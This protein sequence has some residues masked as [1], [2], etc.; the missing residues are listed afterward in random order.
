MIALTSTQII[1]LTKYNYN[2][3]SVPP[4]DCVDVRGRGI[5]HGDYFYFTIPKVCSSS[6]MSMIDGESELGSEC[7][8]D[9][10]I[11]KKPV[12][13]I[14]D[15]VSRWLS[16]T[17]EFL[18]KFKVDDI[19]S[20]LN[21]DVFEIGFD[22]HTAPQ[23]WFLP[24]NLAWDKIEIINYTPTVL[25]EMQV[26]GHFTGLNIEFR[27]PTMGDTKKEILPKLMER[28][29]DPDFIMRIQD[30]YRRD[31]ELISQANKAIKSPEPILNSIS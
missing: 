21:Q 27:N 12:M 15:P 17:L 20:F 4:E 9:P 7:D 11:H 31:Y 10:V 23:T 13:I 1:S 3:R 8:Y 29:S 5:T 25:A 28:Y 6:I 16:G 14:R 30:F 18:K 22:R 2:T 24:Y 26:N 19:S